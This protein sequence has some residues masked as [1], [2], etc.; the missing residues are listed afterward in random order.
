MNTI[1]HCLP[2]GLRNAIAAALV[3]FLCCASAVRADEVAANASGRLAEGKRGMVVSV[4]P[5]ASRIGADALRHGGNAVDSAVATAFALAVVWPEAGNIGGGGFMMIM[6]ADRSSPVCV[7]YRETAPAASTER[8]F[9]PGESNYTHKAVGTPGTIAGLSL[10]HT[11]YG[12]LPWKQLVEPAIRLAS[13]GFDLDR[14]TANSLNAALKGSDK[15]PELR[16]VYGKPGGKRWEAGDRLKLPELAETLRKIAD[17][18]ANAFY[19]GKIAEQIVAEMKRGGGIITLEDLKTYQAKVREPIHGTFRGYDIYAPPPPSSGGICL[20]QILNLVECQPPES[21]VRNSVA[22]YHTTIEAMRRAY[23]DRAKYLGDEDFIDVP[24]RLTTK[25]YAS[26][27]A[28]SIDLHCATSSVNLAP[29]IKI[30]EVSPDTT[31]FSIVDAAGMAVSNTYTLEQS[32][33]SHVVVAGAGFL[34]NNEMGDFNWQP[35]R[36]DAAGRIGTKANVI[37]PKKRMLSSQTPTI[38]ARDGKPY[39]VTG[40][41]GGRTIIN[42]V[43]CVVDNVLEY[44][45]P[46]RAAVD[47][48]R[49]HHAWL[50]DRVKWERPAALSAAEAAK[51]DETI[52][53]LR[54]LGHKIDVVAHQGDAHS[55]L[56]RDGVRTGYADGRIDGA[57]VAE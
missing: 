38:V 23:C 57:A 13:D 50:P 36:T 45:M 54:K 17:G 3:I 9:A 16:R 56:I 18:G 48:P 2:R 20:V 41:P 43:F 21:R 32:F 8:M 14:A 40:S 34:L 51:S 29:A 28:A 22:A 31:H 24:R 1:E 26:Q 5:Y 47:A 10:A 39:L 30:A 44:D 11:R 52:A 35:G 25:E 4:S 7:D 49:I 19:R 6:P 27:L 37:A 55:I 42:T 46:L 53:E 15:F 33:G 12:K